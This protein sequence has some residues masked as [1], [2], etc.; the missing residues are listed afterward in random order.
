TRKAVYARQLEIVSLL[1][2]E[3]VHFLAGTDLA[4]PYIYPGFSLHDELASLVAA[5]F[6]PAEALRAATLDP[7]RYLGAADS[8]GSIEPGKR[9]DLVLLSA[10]PLDD[11]RNTTKL[12][13]VVAAGRLY[14]SAAIAKL[15]ADGVARAGV[16]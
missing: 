15:L 8:L 6:T 9:A 4:N 5:G 2:R 12:V 16:P 13:A 11:I 3:G 10:N 14:D 1:H 7:A